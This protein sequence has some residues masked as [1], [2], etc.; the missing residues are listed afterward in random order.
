MIRKNVSG[1]ERTPTAIK[2]YNTEYLIDINETTPVTA[3][4]HSV[5]HIQK[6]TAVAI[7]SPIITFDNECILSA[8]SLQVI[9]LTKIGSIL[10]CRVEKSWMVLH[11]PLGIVY[12]AQVKDDRIH[13]TAIAVFTKKE[14]QAILRESGTQ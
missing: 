12:D 8:L 1:I 2:V 6:A 13:L 10:I 4:G 7:T 3:Y 14:V 9:T 5:V 11:I